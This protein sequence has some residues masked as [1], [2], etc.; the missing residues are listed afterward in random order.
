[1]RL[2][3]L[4]I[5]LFAIM[6]MTNCSKIDIKNGR[7]FRYYNGGEYYGSNPSMS[8]DGTKIVF[9]SIRYN[10][11]D[12]CIVN[13]DGSNWKRLTNTNSYEG[14]AKFSPDGLKIVFVSERDDNN[15]GHIYVMNSDGSNLVRLTNMK[16]Y[17]SSPSFSPDGCKIVFTRQL[18]TYNNEIFIMNADGSDQ[19]RLTFTNIGESNPLFLYDKNKIYYSILNKNQRV[20]IWVMNIDDSKSAR[21]LEMEKDVS[22]VN[23]S[24]DGQ[25]I[26]F[27]SSKGTNYE[28]DSYTNIEIWIMNRN[29]KRQKQLTHTTHYKSFSTFTPDGNKILFLEHEKRGRGKGQIR[30]IDTDG[31]N[32]RTITNNY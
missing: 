25:K 13:R 22:F 19:K 6:F 3:R 31:T 32:L 27:L 21:L 2:N 24:F 5:I 28:N 29:N 26:V 7:G 11:G 18:Q 10:A 23:I 20:E 4:V 12:I 8:P 15:T 1:M 16:H 14:E 30:I 17:D 9:G